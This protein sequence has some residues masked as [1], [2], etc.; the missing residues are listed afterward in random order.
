MATPELYQVVGQNNRNILVQSKRVAP[1]HEDLTRITTFENSSVQ[2]GE[3]TTLRLDLKHATDREL[4][5]NDLRLRFKVDFSARSAASLVQGVC[6]TRMTDLIR[7]LRI[8]INEDEVFKV[9][10]QGELSL[11]WEMN[12]H[13]TGGKQKEISDS[14]LMNHGNIPSGRAVSLY[15]DNATTPVNWYYTSAKSYTDA[16]P[17]NSPGFYTVTGEERHDGFPRLIFDDRNYPTSTYMYQADISLN[18]LVGPI[19]H[20]LHLR[21]IEFVQIEIRFE[22]WVSAQETQKFCLFT[23]HPTVSGTAAHP[24]SVVRFTNL[25]VQ[26][27]RTTLLDGICGFT[28]PDNR[29]LSWLMHRFTWRDYP[30]NMTTTNT[31][32]IQLHDFE[33][34]TNIVRVWWTILSETDG[35][36]NTYAPLLPPGKFTN[37]YGVEL[38]WQNDKVLDLDTYYQ[39]QRH[40]ILSHNK[41]YGVDEPYMKC[42]RLQDNGYN[43]ITPSTTTLPRLGVD[44]ECPFYSWDCAHV[45]NDVAKKD[46]AYY[47]IP[48]YY[49]DLNMNIQV[50]CPGAEHIGGIVND[51]S[52][53]V[54]RLKKCTMDGV[55]G[56]VTLRV[57]LEYQTMVN[58]SAGSNQFN[59]G[60][61]VI[62]KQLNL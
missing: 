62:T 61:Q 20:K 13:Y 8:K 12:N 55:G 48:M 22:P 5:L 34:R 18:Q 51:T 15:P 11:L 59:R 2:P 9:D 26:Q 7:E 14:V 43:R 33:L 47:E 23:K 31:F 17:E 42:Y 32:D 19:F 46:L 21:R 53:Y 38:L 16:A 37:L 1:Y 49:V 35:T 57:F 58:L 54:V 60:S 36:K 44:Q 28:L 40:Y 50:G 25:E 27:Y 41:R 45:F 52:N 30:I 10:R 6:V 24:Y 56:N 3:L 4:I 39:V 29:M